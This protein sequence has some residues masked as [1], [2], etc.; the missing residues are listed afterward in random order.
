[1]YVFITKEQKNWKQILK[2]LQESV[3]KSAIYFGMH[4]KS[5]FIDG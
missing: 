4:P 3:L 2:Y 5:K 1:M